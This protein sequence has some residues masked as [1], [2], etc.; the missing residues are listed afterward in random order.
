MAN[1]ASLHAVVRGR[2]QGVS[3]RAFVVERANELG[4][5][6]EVRNLPSGQDVEVWAEG[7][8][9]KLEELVKYLEVGPP[10]ARI[11]KVTAVWSKYQ[12]KYSRF[13]IRY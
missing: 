12:G 8:K 11:E 6:G 7:N 3:F 1:L 9:E 2:V 10:A 4:L 13:K 5:T